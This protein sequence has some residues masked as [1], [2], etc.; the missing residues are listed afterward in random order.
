MNGIFLSP[1]G[2]LYRAVARARNSLYEKGVFKSCS[3][4]APTVSIGNITVGGTGKTPL[5][6]R[7]AQILAGDGNRVCILTR[8]Y[9]RENP[10]ERVLVSD[11]EKILADVKKAGDEPFELACKL[12]GVSAVAVIADRN[13]AGAGIWARENLGITAFVLDDAFQHRR[14]RRD[15]DIV[16]VDATNPFG[17]GKILPG[18][19]LREPL[20]NLKRADAIVITRANLVEAERIAELKR[21][22]SQI[23]PDGK[24]F[25]SENKISNLINLKEFPAKAQSGEGAESA[26]ILTSGGRQAASNYAAFCALGNPESFFEQLR[27]EKFN[28]IF[29]RVFR[30][31]HRYT[32]KD[33]DEMER[34]AAAGGAQIF[35]TTAKD[36]VKLKDLRFSVPCRVAEIELIFDDEKSFRNLIADASRKRLAAKG[37][38]K[39]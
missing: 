19:I 36:A 21:R 32:Q 33:V 29:T 7:V 37:H 16:C 26:A 30:D 11:G 4:G 18:G 34:E 35:L 5:V 20:P 1:F 13:R 25:V 31:H 24:I 27:R 38:E 2:L 8:G 22:L 10:G 6:A 15:L 17:N 14:V 28:L 12:S 9:K 23:N 39:N 3:L